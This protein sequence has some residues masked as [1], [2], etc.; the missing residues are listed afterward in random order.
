MEQVASIAVGSRRNEDIALD[1]MKFVAITTGYGKTGAPGAGFQGSTVS[2]AE[3]Y[4]AHLLELYTQC[5]RAVQG[6]K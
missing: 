1:L 3:D 5:L 2:K 4:A 6:G